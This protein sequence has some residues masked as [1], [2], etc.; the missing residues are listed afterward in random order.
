MYQLTDTSQEFF[1]HLGFQMFQVLGVGVELGR[2]LRRGER[3]AGRDNVV[4]L[5]H[6]LWQDQFEA[7]LASSAV[8][9]SWAASGGRWR[10]SRLGIL[11][12]RTPPRAS[13]CHR[14]SIRVIRPPTGRVALASDR[15]TP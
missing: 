8:S 5:S 14:T 1:K 3:E 13:G 9:L 4:I 11:S 7:I 10:A 2:S 12:S 15:Q 6:E